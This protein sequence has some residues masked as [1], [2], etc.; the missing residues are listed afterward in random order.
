MAKKSLEKLKL[1]HQRL[2]KLSQT[3]ER[4]KKIIFSKMKA[5]VNKA[6]ASLA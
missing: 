2:D 5:G 4:L 1:L 6:M 3:H